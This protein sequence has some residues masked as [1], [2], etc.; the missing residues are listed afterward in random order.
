MSK[1]SKYVLE[2]KPPNGK[3]QEL[4]KLDYE[5][6]PDSFTDLSPGWSYRFVAH[7]KTI[8]RRIKRNILWTYKEPRRRVSEATKEENPNLAI[9]KA[10]AQLISNVATNADMSGLKLRKL[11]LPQLAGVNLEFGSGDEGRATG[12]T[13]RIGDSEFPIDAESLGGLKFEGGVPW[14]LH[15]IPSAMLSNM[16]KGIIGDIF[17]L[18]KGS[19]TGEG[20][21]GLTG[22]VANDIE[23]A[24]KE[25]KEKEKKEKPELYADEIDKLLKEKKKIK[26]KA[27]EIAEEI[28]SGETEEGEIEEEG[29]ESEEETDMNEKTDEEVVKVVRGG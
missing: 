14:W 4:V 10:V 13:V 23:K 27:E 11:V 22:S 7:S 9:Q 18:L 21:E 5:A 3:W 16:I 8:F 1:I 20:L 28:E 15:P 29:E 24:I 12:G 19:A 25:E 17:G 2:G 6:T 26:E